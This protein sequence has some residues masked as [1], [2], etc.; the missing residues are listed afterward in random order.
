MRFSYSA[1]LFMSLAM[2]ALAL[3]DPTRVSIPGLGEVEGL[4]DT[5][6]SSRAFRGIPYGESTAPP[7]RY[8]APVA[9]APWPGPLKAHSFG[10]GCESPVVGANTP[11]VTSEDCLSL[12]VFTPLSVSPESKLPVLVW[13]YGGSFSSGS[14]GGPLD[15][16]DGSFTAG[17][18]GVVVVTLNYRHSAFGFLVVTGQIDGNM[19]LLD[20][21]LALKWVHDHIAA[22]GGNSARVTL[23][24]ESAGAWSIAL[25]LVS[26]ASFPYYSR[27]IMFSHPIGVRMQAQ[28]D[29]AIYGRE[30]CRL[31]GCLVS[32]YVGSD[33][34]CDVRCL[35]E[36]SPAA[37]KRD[38]E[39]VLGNTT[40]VVEANGPHLIN[41]LLGFKPV[42]DGKLVPDNFLELLERGAINPRAQIVVGS[43]ADEATVFAYAVEK[44]PKMSM[45][46]YSVAASAAFGVNHGM[47]LSYL[48]GKLFKD[49]Y[50]AL[51]RTVTDMWFRCAMQNFATRAQE[52]SGLPAYVYRYTHV[53]QSPDVVDFF[54]FPRECRTQV[55]HAAELPFVF[56]F[57]ESKD[58]HVKA[59]M[60]P[61]ELA[62]SRQIVRFIAN[63]A[64][65][66]NPAADPAA[67]ATAVAAAATATGVNREAEMS[68][69]FGRG[70]AGDRELVARLRAAGVLPVA[71]AAGLG[72]SP[73]W[74]AWDR[75]TRQNIVFRT[76]FAVENSKELCDLWDTIGYR[77]PY[78][79]SR[80]DLHAAAAAGDDAEALR[81]QILLR[82]PRTAEALRRGD[83]IDAFRAAATEAK[84]AIDA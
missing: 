73:N 9:K 14:G 39:T 51:S 4:V 11:A 25:H 30:F 59:K 40:V 38:L 46:E 1:L 21:R 32:E 63:F 16:Y 10:P 79:G 69:V 2:I 8:G 20:Q 33:Y 76:G 22:F 26:E 66:G 67:D 48:Y 50:A 49:G 19:G 75:K 45:T 57:A 58:P 52:V 77:V 24:G 61:D 55:C 17:T 3:S 7:H 12:N 27:A 83:L 68:A 28:H 72:S 60:T 44:P 31:Q 29:A 84:N 82:M 70:S 35:Q 64:R 43:T 34:V 37:V 78:I 5:K 54:E 47:R 53:F 80:A 62:L 15:M 18:E 71:T 65:T 41:A 13:L 6:T 36:T 74:P 56:H 23:F 42:V 81:A